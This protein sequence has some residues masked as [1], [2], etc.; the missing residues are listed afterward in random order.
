[1]KSMKHVGQQPY[2]RSFK[3][4][5]IG[6]LNSYRVAFTAAN[7]IEDSFLMERYFYFDTSV[8]VLVSRITLEMFISY[9]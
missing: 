6:M 7:R 9:Y 8:P 4:V 5:P 1:M 2:S 3:W